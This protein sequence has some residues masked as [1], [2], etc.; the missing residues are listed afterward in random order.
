MNLMIGVKLLKP[1]VETENE[2]IEKLNKMIDALSQE[3][4]RKFFCGDSCAK[5]FRLDILHDNGF[6]HCGE[7]ASK[8]VFTPSIESDWVIKIPQLYEKGYDGFVRRE[9]CISINDM[10]KRQNCSKPMIFLFL[11]TL[12][13]K[14]TVTYL[15]QKNLLIYQKKIIKLLENLMIIFLMI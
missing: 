14:F 8:N 12:R 10:Y 1:D 4:K 15:V 11:F 7:G 2:L 9:N 5:K 3:E 6:I 13:K